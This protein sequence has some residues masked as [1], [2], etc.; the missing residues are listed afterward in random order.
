MMAEANAAAGPSRHGGFLAG[1]LA[2][3]QWLK[4]Q[5]MRWVAAPFQL[6]LRI[7]IFFYLPF[8]NSGLT[9]W[10]VFPF[11][12]PVPWTWNGWP[13]VS[14]GV[15]YQFSNSCDFCFNIRVLG[16][17]PQPLLRWVLPFPETMA[18]LAGLA[19]LVL[20]TLVL[21]GLLTRLSA[22]GL[23]GMTVVIQLVIPT[24][25]MVHGGWAIAFIGLI[26]LGPG[27]ISLDHLLGRAIRR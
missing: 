25:F 9:K 4:G 23:L 2:F 26:L 22:L 27:L 12:K 18:G 1:I 5:V 7:W 11:L 10:E 6:A 21:I 19:E 8:V 17:E 14:A 20:P 3:D 24:G 15:K 16:A 13:Q